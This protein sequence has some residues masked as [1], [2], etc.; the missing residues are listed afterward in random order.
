MFYCI[1]HP[2]SVHFHHFICT[3]VFHFNR[4]GVDVV[5]LLSF[6]KPE[7]IPADTFKWNFCVWQTAENSAARQIFAW[8]KAIMTNSEL[9]SC[10][11]S[12]LLIW[13]ELARNAPLTFLV[14]MLPYCVCSMAIFILC[15]MFFFRTGAQ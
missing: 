12:K 4:K 10:F 2:M 11:F 15:Q 1:L 8:P 14:V 3:L 13:N 6:D 5:V 9:D 7:G